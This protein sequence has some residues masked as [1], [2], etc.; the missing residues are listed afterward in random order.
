MTYRLTKIFKKCKKDEK[1]VALVEFAIAAPVLA[2]LLLSAVDMT[3]YLVAH[4]RIARAAYT[5]SNLLTQMDKGLKEAQVSDMML[6]L[7]RVSNPF[8]IETDGIATMTAII[9]NGSVGAAPDNYTVAWKRCFGSKTPSATYGASGSLVS[10]SQFPANT[11]VTSSQVLVVTEISYDFVPTIG[12]LPLEGKIE[13]TSYFRP[14][15]GSIENI[16]NDGTSAH[17]CP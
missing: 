6:A 10:A 8:D 11:I 1:G 13:Y 5:M 3:M 4:Q 14:R 12:F 17:S 15:R 9:G 7:N 16:V 2:A